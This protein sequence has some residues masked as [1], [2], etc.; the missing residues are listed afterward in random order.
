MGAI[1]VLAKIR[2]RGRLM[3]Y[4]L[5]QFLRRDHLTTSDLEIKVSH[6]S[7]QGVMIT[8][9]RRYILQQQEM[10]VKVVGR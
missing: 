7:V 1:S 5:W 2:E 3:D 10:L 9:V 4:A 8:T 6:E